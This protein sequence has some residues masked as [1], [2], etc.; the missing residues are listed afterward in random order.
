[1]A[2]DRRWI[3]GG[4]LFVGGGI[5][6]VRLLTAHPKIR[7]DTRLLVIGD[8]LAEGLHPHFKQL[9]ADEDIVYLGRGVRGSRIDQW[10]ASAWLDQALVDF[11]PT[12]T[13]VS[14]GTNDEYMSGDAVARQKPHLDELLSKLEAS[15]TD[16]V[17]IGVP[18]LPKEESNGIAEMIEESVKYYF[19]SE[20]LEIP[21]GPDDLH[22]TAAGYAGWAGALWQWLS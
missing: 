10:A 9:A 15:G 18:E 14:L 13:L 11:Q 17:W 2:L 19:P 3:L 8:S 12:L 20:S 7:D 21:R 6:L 5:G 22:P 1:M 16:I 4:L